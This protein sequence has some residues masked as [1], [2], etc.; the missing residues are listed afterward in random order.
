MKDF[1]LSFREIVQLVLHLPCMQPPPVQ[2]IY[3]LHIWFCPPSPIEIP[4]HRIR[5]PEQFY[6]YIYKPSSSHH[7]MIITSSQSLWSRKPFLQ[8]LYEQS[9]P[10]YDQVI[11]FHR[12][13]AL[14]LEL[15]TGKE[16]L[17]YTQSYLLGLEKNTP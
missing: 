6:L 14:F 11:K 4:G 15:R 13:I 2:S 17:F 10:V 5:S 12:F 3:G 9:I 1:K 16:S 8:L 7:D